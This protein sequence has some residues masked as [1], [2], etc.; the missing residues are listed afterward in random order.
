[1]W[2]LRAESVAFSR[3]PHLQRKIN[4]NRDQTIIRLLNTSRDNDRLTS[5]QFGR[6]A[7]VAPCRAL[8]SHPELM[9]VSAC[10]RPSQ[11][12]LIRSKTR[13]WLYV[14]LY[15]PAWIP[16]WACQLISISVI[17]TEV[18][19]LVNLSPVTLLK[20]DYSLKLKERPTQSFNINKASWIL[21]IAE[22]SAPSLARSLNH[23][24]RFD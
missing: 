2:S 23:R 19:Q 18:H 16:S 1:M 3:L 9:M 11:A 8:P 24:V 15:L 21:H 5:S 7:E 13:G 14:Q 22:P 10:P 6:E 4:N 17:E 12:C 20:L